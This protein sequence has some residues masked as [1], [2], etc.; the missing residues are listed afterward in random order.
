MAKLIGGALAGMLMGTVLLAGVAG[1]IAP[2]AE[3]AGVLIAVDVAPGTAVLGDG[4]RLRQV[5]LNLT[6]NAIKFTETGG[7]SVIVEAGAHEGEIAFAVRDTGIGIA[8]DQLARIFHEFEQA[9][10]GANRK[11]SGTGLG[12]AISRRIVERM[13]GR[14]EV[15]SAPGKGTRMRVFL[16]ALELDDAFAPADGA[17]ELP[18]IRPGA[19]APVPLRILVIDDEPNVRT[20][21]ADLL[22]ASGHTVVEAANGRDAL[23]RMESDDAWDLVMTDLGMPDLSGWDVARAVGAR[24]SPPPVILVTGWGIQLEDRILAESGVAAVVAKPFT[25]EEVLTAVERVLRNAA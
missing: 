25:I 11:F 13:G 22:R 17:P 16:P 1:L 5:L 6:G 14:I 4:E 15:V 23:Q 18:A 24:P 8:A 20:L 21:L 19:S 12:L 2:E 10:S 9:E 3:A 7:V